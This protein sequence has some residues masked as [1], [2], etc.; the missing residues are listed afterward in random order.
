MLTLLAFNMKYRQLLDALKTELLVVRE[1]LFVK[2]LV[3]HLLK[4]YSAVSAQQMN[5]SGKALYREVLLYSKRVDRDLV[6][7]ILE[8]AED[9]A[10]QWTTGQDNVF[11]FRQVV[12]FLILTQYIQSGHRGTRI[13]FREI[14]YAR[15][16]SKL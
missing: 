2:C 5:L 4:S 15:V 3:R 13:S 12:H 14:V 8:Q 9:S 7:S 16:S 6:D 10:D 11:G 1:T